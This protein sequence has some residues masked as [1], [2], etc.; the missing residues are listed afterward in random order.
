MK[1]ALLSA[2]LVRTRVASLVQPL[3]RWTGVIG[4]NYHRIGD[5]GAS[6]FDR[7]IWSA[8]AA[9]FDEQL[10]ALKRDADV[11]S[12][13]DLDER[14]ARRR[15]RSV[16]ITFDDGYL[17]NYTTAFPLLKR[18]GLPATF[19]VT[20]GFLDT[21]RLPW[22]DEIAWM[23]RSAR[24]AH[25]DLP[26]F[27]PTRVA[28]DEPS[29]EQAVRTVL[30]AFKATPTDGTEAFLSALALATGAGRYDPE[31]ARSLWMTWD[32]IRELRASGMS[33]G[34]HTID[35]P[36]LAQMSDEGQR[37]QITGCAARLE[38]ELG[39][40]MR[41]FAYPVGTRQAFNEATRA[42]L[43][44]C[45]VELGFSYYGGFRR[46]DDW[47]PFD[48]RRMSVEHTTSLDE[49]RARVLLPQVFARS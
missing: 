40:R 32:M 39:E 27:I 38:S 43:R 9:G 8:S 11:V 24:G 45:G 31:Q 18:H 7:G 25:L 29:R 14:H 13:D 42:C 28:F 20:T 46:F 16:L 49:F 15:G 26:G 19:F 21:P 6:P 4:L 37:D 36:I 48:V 22:W 34:G 23:M 33:I 17:D 41:W 12:V 35:H 2:V 47:D 44:A 5:G 3:V 10:A 30:R 1:R